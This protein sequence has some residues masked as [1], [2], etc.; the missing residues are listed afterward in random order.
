[1]RMHDRM[2]VAALVRAAAAPSLSSLDGGE[3]PCPGHPLHS[4]NSHPWATFSRLYHQ[5]F[6]ALPSTPRITT[7][8]SRFAPE[9]DKKG[10]RPD[11]L[12]SCAAFCHISMY[13]A[14]SG[15]PT[16]WNTPPPTQP[17]AAQLRP[18]TPANARF[19][20]FS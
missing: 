8:R 16:S 4:A 18:R 11:L 9:E 15:R 19:V 7:S 5:G 17:A 6:V 13:S 2:V 12:V 14:V 10:I 1:M 20:T 3:G